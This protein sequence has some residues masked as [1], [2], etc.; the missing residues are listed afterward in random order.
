VSFY[1]FAKFKT[2]SSVEETPASY[3]NTAA[4]DSKGKN[5]AFNNCNSLKTYYHTAE[6]PATSTCALKTACK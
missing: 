1:F 4:F 3:L 5:T 2:Y 6:A